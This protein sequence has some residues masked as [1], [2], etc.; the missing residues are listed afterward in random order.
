MSNPVSGHPSQVL[1]HL[2]RSVGQKVKETSDVKEFYIG[3][4]SNGQ[5][6][7]NA[8][9]RG[10]YRPMG[11]DN[12]E[13]IYTTVSDKNRKTVEKELVEHFGYHEKLGN[14]IGG[15]GGPKGT[16]EYTVYMATKYYNEAPERVGPNGGTYFY[17]SNGNK[18]YGDREYYEGPNGGRYYYTASGNKVYL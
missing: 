5:E 1:E 13:P 6:G 11:Y 10:K 8:R 17:N 16:P 9:M 4:A 3:I 2:H 15:G 18:T 12:I 14:Q 7:V